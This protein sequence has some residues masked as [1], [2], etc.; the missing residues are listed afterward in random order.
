MN[1]E[2]F[3]KNSKC[4]QQL[5]FG[6]LVYSTIFPDD[7][8]FNTASLG[9]AIVLR[10][11][12]V[13]LVFFDNRTCVDK[14]VHPLSYQDSKF[15]YVSDPTRPMTVIFDLSLLTIDHVFHFAQQFFFISTFDFYKRCDLVCKS[16]VI[17]HRELTF[18]PTVQSSR[19]CLMLQRTK[20]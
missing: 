19:L 12:S 10:I 3:E 6:V 8:S 16:Q 13:E 11:S 15:I 7:S 5:Q 1:G 4:F 2:F 20:Y 9:N 17:I 18:I 14:Y